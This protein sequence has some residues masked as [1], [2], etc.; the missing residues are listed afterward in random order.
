MIA[1]ELDVR[2]VVLDRTRV[3]FAKDQIGAN[4]DQRDRRRVDVD[5]RIVVGVSKSERA[6]SRSIRTRCGLVPLQYCPGI[7]DREAERIRLLR[8]RILVGEALKVRRRH[9]LTSSFVNLSGIESMRSPWAG[10]CW[11]LTLTGASLP[12]APEP[13]RRRDWT[14]SPLASSTDEKF[15]SKGRRSASGTR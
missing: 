14:V 7:A 15:S 13:R 12:V 4:P 9:L 11:I 1:R 8:C 10:A 2:V 6:P 3:S 5:W